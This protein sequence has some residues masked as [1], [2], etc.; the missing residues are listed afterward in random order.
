MR[1]SE[2]QK[3]KDN[4]RQSKNKKTVSSDKSRVQKR[5]AGNKTKI[6]IFIN[7]RGTNNRGD[8][9]GKIN[10]I[11]DCLVAE[12][13]IADDRTSVLQNT[14]STFQKSKQAGIDIIILEASK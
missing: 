13:I 3:L 5:D 11:L 8:L 12:R 9:D 4:L 7:V 2:F 10:T 1:Y 14:V 6:A